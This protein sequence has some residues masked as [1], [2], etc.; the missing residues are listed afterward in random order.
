[1][2]NVKPFQLLYHGTCIDNSKS[3]EEKGLV[4]KDD[5]YVY[6]TSDLHVAYE[7]ALRT[8]CPPVICIIDAPAMF[9]DGHIFYKE[10]F[11]FEWLTATV[12]PKYILQIQIEDESDLD[13]IYN[14]ISV[15]RAGELF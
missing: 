14:S 3:I 2:Q 10:Q 9:R 6:L 8:N 15:L 4:G 1:M 11:E 5:S 7:Y 12:P 13:M